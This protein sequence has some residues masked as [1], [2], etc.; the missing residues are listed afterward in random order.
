MMVGHPVKEREENSEGTEYR[1][2]ESVGAGK[3]AEESNPNKNGADRF[4]ALFK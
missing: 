1:A 2:T 4:T 3:K